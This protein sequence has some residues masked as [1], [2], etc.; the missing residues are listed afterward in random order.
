MT[1]ELGHRV[2][3][4]NVQDL[5]RKLSVAVEQ[6]RLPRQLAALTQPKLLIVDEVGIWNWGARRQASSSR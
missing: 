6:N 4:T 3:F 1:C 2:Y 5:A